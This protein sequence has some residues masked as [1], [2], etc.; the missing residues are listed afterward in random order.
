MKL[1]SIRKILSKLKYKF[2]QLL[3]TINLKYYKVLTGKNLT[4]NGILRLRKNKT[5]CLELGDSIIINSSWKANPAGGGQTK[6]LFVVS[7]N[8]S[9]SIGNWSGISN[10]TIFCKEKIVIGNHVNIGVNCIIY[11]TDMHSINYEGRIHI[12]EEYIETKPV[13]IS[14]GAWICG[15]CIILKGV[16]IGERSVIGAGFVVTHDVPNDELWAGNP[17]K[18]IKKLNQN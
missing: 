11:D 13:V 6:C 7:N 3:N 17:A 2:F 12:T 16:T 15:H 14:D 4:I 8:A 1:K 10:S 18:F 9:L 5:A